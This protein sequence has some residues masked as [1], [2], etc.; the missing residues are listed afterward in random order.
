M[1]TTLSPRE[2]ARLARPYPGAFLAYGADASGDVDAAF[3]D[4][5][6]QAGYDLGFA[7]V[8]PSVAEID[9]T[10]VHVACTRAV[11]L[12]AAQL[13]ATRALAAGDL[14]PGQAYALAVCP[15]GAFKRRRVRLTTTDTDRVL[16]EA[17]GALD[18]V[19]PDLEARLR[20]LAEATGGMGKE[21]LVEAVE[22]LT[23]RHRFRPAVEVFRG[24]SRARFVVLDPCRGQIVAE[25]GEDG[26]PFTTA[27]QARRAA[28]A[29]LKAGQVG[30]D[31]TGHLDV[32]KL[33]GREGG[34]PLV[35]VTRTRVASRV[36]VKVTVSA[37]KNPAKT[38]T[39]GWLFYGV[40]PEPGAQDAADGEG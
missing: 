26:Q 11:P 32:V 36:V 1:S 17:P 30:Q 4:A 27:G 8:L 25:A 5:V 31:P 28:V 15:D 37:E 2:A 9:A 13:T 29:L 40:V 6:E 18:V 7:G 22:V 39:V 35:R 10:E 24:P 33:S 19:T 21:E 16:A 34:L 38:R 14:V 12:A 23:A 20:D 3:D